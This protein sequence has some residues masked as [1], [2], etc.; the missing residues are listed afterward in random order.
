MT[1]QP[2]TAL[3]EGACL[4]AKIPDSS[5][6]RLGAVVLNPYRIAPLTAVIRDG[7]QTIGDARVRVLGRGEQG[8][9][10]DYPVRDTTLLQHG[11]IPVFGL[12]P[13]HVNQV[14]VAYTLNGERVRERYRIYAPAVRLP[15]IAGQ[16]GALPRVEPLTVDP[17][18]KKRLYLFNHL[19]TEIPGNRQLKWNAQGGA[20]EWDSLGINWIADTQGEVRWY[21]DIERLHDSGHVDG[22]GASMG[23]QQTADG[24][25]VWG[26]G[27]RYYKHDLLGRPLWSGACRP[28]SPTSPMKSARPPAAPTCCGWPAATPG[29]PTASRCAACATTSWKSTATAKC[30]TSGTSG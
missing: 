26:Q 6:S 28:N 23:F 4:T 22:L 1:E 15:A 27:Q 7:G 19:L 16:S 9:D 5:T 29:A 24:K 13:D 10:I 8:I 20:A 21:L 3:P 2:P 11:G 14:E 30:S 17:T 12:Y 18:L 25:L